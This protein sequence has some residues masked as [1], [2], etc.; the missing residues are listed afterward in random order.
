MEASDMLDVIHYF[1]EEDM[2]YHTSEQATFHGQTRQNMYRALYGVEYSYFVASSG[3]GAK[4]FG[5]G[6]STANGSRLDLPEDGFDDEPVVP[7]NP[8][9]GKPE[10]KPYF[11]ATQLTGIDSNPFGGVLDSPLGY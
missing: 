4:S 5:E 10:T 7:F 9:G 3:N 8:K 11:P 6:L 1:F 2:N